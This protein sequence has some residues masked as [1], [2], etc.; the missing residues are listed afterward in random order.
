MAV[1]IIEGAQSQGVGTSLK[2]YAAN[3]QET[4]R[5]FNNSLVSERAMRELYLRAFEIAVKRA[6]PWT[7]M[8]T[9][10]KLNGTYTS[11]RHDLNTQIL[12]EEWGFTGVVM[13]DWYSGFPD[14]ADI[15]DDSFINDV[16]AQI[17]A[18]ND[19]TMPGMDRQQAAVLADIESGALSMQAVDTAVTNVLKMIFKTPVAKHYAYNDQ[20]DLT[21]HAQLAR[22]I[23]AQGVVMLKNEDQALPLNFSHHKIAPFGVGSTHLITGGTGSSEI[24]T[25]YK[26]SVVDGLIGN[27][28]Q[29]DAD[30]VQKYKPYTQSFVAQ[31]L[32]SRVS[33]LVPFANVPELD[34]TDAEIEQAATNNTVALFT[35]GRNATEKFFWCAGRQ[36]YRYSLYR[37]CVCGLSLL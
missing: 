10:N 5:T 13:T 6:K 29:V 31:D 15:L 35:I 21:A 4:N 17:R 22:Q 2:H 34:F 8:T 36:P 26:V 30:L 28:A 27:E 3:N 20:P 14:Q 37:R 19:L 32:A 12:R 18:G 7:L 24:T 1:P 16:S 11:E 9:Y 25:K 23:V 33:K